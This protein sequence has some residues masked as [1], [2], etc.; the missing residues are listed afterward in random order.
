MERS[1]RWAFDNL[2][3]LRLEEELKVLKLIQGDK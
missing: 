2:N 3:R 1:E